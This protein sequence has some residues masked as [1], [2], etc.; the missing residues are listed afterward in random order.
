MFDSVLELRS[1][2]A[3]CVSGVLGNVLYQRL[4]L[5]CSIQALFKLKPK[6][7]LHTTILLS[8]LPLFFFP[9]LSIKLQIIPQLFW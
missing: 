9:P 3:G 4:D 2:F 8:C 6:P 7:F 1:R 5:K